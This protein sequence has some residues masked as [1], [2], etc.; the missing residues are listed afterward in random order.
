MSTA[1][2][3]ILARIRGVLEKTAP[4]AR[5]DEARLLNAIAQRRTCVRPALAGEAAA[6]FLAKAEANLISVREL[7]SL[8]EVPAAVGEILRSENLASDI[9]IAPT[10][11]GLDWPATISIRSAKA[12]LDE[13]L[14]V[15]IAIAAIAETGSL[16]LC[17]GDGAPS[18]LTYAGERHVIVL[19]RKDIRGYLEDGLAAVKATQTHWPRTV[20]L[21]SGP[22]RTADVAG[23]V[24]RPAHGPK[25]VDVLLI[26]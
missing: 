6:V 3:E 10:L 21:V 15:S 4:S 19:H 16:V 18:S 7:A 12:R 20:N 23:I 5:S 25:A 14:T 13:K 9:S 1:R 26:S 17:S 11:L 22:S 24:V 8:S 2:E